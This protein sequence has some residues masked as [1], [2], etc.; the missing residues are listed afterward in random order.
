MFQRSNDARTERRRLRVH[1]RWFGQRYHYGVYA[2]H[3]QP[4]LTVA[5]NQII[6][7]SSKP[8]YNITKTETI[9]LVSYGVRKVLKKTLIPSPAKKKKKKTTLL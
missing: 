2:I 9:Q 1:G 5:A 8:K 4:H 6:F 3:S 7:I